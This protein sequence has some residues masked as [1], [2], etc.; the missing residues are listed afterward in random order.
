MNKTI[1][2]YENFLAYGAVDG[3]NHSYNIPESNDYNS[4]DQKPAVILSSYGPPKPTISYIH[5]P[6]QMYASPEYNGK[7]R[8]MSKE[9]EPIKH[10]QNGPTLTGIAQAIH[11]H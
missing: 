7:K 4:F 9:F 5:D 1:K 3:P 10:F 11:A 6:H 8:S 2:L